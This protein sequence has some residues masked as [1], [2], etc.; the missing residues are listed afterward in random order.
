MDEETR[1]D[2]D[3]LNRRLRK[4]ARR[5]AVVDLD[6]KKGVLNARVDT[7]KLVNDVIDAIGPVLEHEDKGD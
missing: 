7:T 3:T 5:L 6:D 1:R 2:L 4:L